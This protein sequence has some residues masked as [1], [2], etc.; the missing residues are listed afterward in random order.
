M[1]DAL[2][3]G[4][5]LY[6]ADYG[7]QRTALMRALFRATVQVIDG[8]EDTT[9]NAEGKLPEYIEDSQF[10]DVKELEVVPTATG[11]IS[12]YEAKKCR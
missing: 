1:Y 4:G 10:G 12:I 5:K 11:S 3:S 8:T 6:I 2:Q 9:P 7:L